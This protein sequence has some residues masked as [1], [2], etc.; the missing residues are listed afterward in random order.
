MPN[1]TLD[2]AAK[3]RVKDALL[4]RAQA[5]LAASRE[6]VQTEGDAAVLDQDDSFSVDDQSQSDQAGDL[7]AL[8]GGAAERQE[9]EVARISALDFSPADAVR[10]GAIVGFGG[11]RYVVGVVTDPLEVDEVTYEGISADAPIYAAIEGRA[12]GDDF[13]FR[14]QSETID[15]LA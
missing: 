15:F 4:A 11:S 8:L 5:E 1:A 13:T 3:A 12:L 14:G 7:H 9:A 6:S 2:G 10:P